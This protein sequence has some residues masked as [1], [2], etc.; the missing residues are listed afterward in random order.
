MNSVAFMHAAYIV[1][2]V[3]LGGYC[4]DL[5]ARYVKLKKELRDLKK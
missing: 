1:V 2:W 3:I 4:A 5:V